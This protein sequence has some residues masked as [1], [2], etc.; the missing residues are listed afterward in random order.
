MKYKITDCKQRKNELPAT[1]A[2][3]PTQAKNSGET[4]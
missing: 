4:K 1:N 2:L 3:Q